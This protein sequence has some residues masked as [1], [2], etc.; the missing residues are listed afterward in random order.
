GSDMTRV[1]F[2]ALDAYGNQRPYPSGDVTLTVTGPGTL[3]GDN[4]FPFATYGGVG[5]AFIRSQAGRTGAVTV[6]ASH[7]TL[8]V[9]SG[10]VAVT[11]ATGRVFP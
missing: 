6:S 4:P 3:I 1:T 2:R 5:G 11:P 10:Q 7:P 8:G 9:A